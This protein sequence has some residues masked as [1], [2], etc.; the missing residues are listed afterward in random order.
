LLD[1]DVAQKFIADAALICESESGIKSNQLKR[2]ALQ[3][4]CG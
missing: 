1:G 2:M 4:I 3:G